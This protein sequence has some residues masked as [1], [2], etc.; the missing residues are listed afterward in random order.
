MEGSP[1]SPNIINILILLDFSLHTLLK[2]AGNNMPCTPEGRTCCEA[3]LVK[4]HITCLH[5]MIVLVLN[6]RMH[7]LHFKNEVTVKR[8]FELHLLNVLCTFF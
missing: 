5:K 1:C 3:N 2:C 4:L 8:L 6:L 7:D